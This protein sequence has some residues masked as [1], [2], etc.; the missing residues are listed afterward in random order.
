MHE[1]AFR[2]SVISITSNFNTPVI[3]TLNEKDTAKY[4]SVLARKKQKSEQP[5]RPSKIH[6]TKKEQLQ[7]ILEGFPNIGPAAAKKLLEEFKSIK[8]IVNS[9]EEELSKVLGKRSGEFCTL[10]NQEC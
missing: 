5:I 3:F 8:Q 9:S 2:G 1:N 7:F 10:V 4:I 6:L